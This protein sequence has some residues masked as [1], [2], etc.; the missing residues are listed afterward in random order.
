LDKFG[1][2]LVLSKL[3]DFVDAVDINSIIGSETILRLEKRIEPVLNASKTYEVFFDAKLHRGTI[4]NRLVSSEFTVNDDFGVTR[5]ATLEETPESFTGI[6]SISVTN[7]GYGYVTPPTVII[8]GDGFGATAVAKIVNGKVENVEVTNRGSNYTKA[9]ISFS[10]GNGFG[11]SAI[12]I[13]DGRFGTLRTVYFNAL[14]ERQIINSSAGTIDYDTGL[15]V[16]NDIRILSVLSSD[17]TIR[18]NVES[19]DGIISSKRNTILTI[20]K[21]DP[22]SVITDLTVA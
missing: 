7:S 16:I 10:G 8:T 21:N 17:N 12:T 15:V 3:Q 18:I 20:D 6:S 22:S 14:A 13:L 4:L 11:A 5:T 9:V 2:T 1:S 19:E